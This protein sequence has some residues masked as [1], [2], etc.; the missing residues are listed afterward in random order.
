MYKDA[1]GEA[2]IGRFHV[3]IAVV[4]GDDHGVVVS[5][6]VINHPILAYVLSF[7]EKQR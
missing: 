4:H 2:V 1:R 7:R 6:H 3:S 5:L